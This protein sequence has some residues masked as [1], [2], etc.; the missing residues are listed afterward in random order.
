MKKIA[1]I[2]LFLSTAAEA[3]LSG[4]ITLQAQN[5]L[6]DALYSNQLD[7]DFSASIQRKYTTAWNNGDDIF[8]GQI[9]GRMGS[10]DEE[11]N[12]MDIREL[13]WLHLAGD[14]EWRIGIDTVFW[15]VTESQN[16]VDVINQKD[17]VEGI[18]NEKKLG[19]P[20]LQFS[21]I[22]DWGVIESYLLFGFRE[23]TFAGE[24]GRLR[25]PLV[26]STSNAL[27]ES[28]E[29]EDHVDYAI[30]Y[31]HFYDDIDYAVSLFRGT[32]REPVLKQVTIN[33]A[34]VL[35]P[36]YVQIT[37]IGVEAQTI[38]D[39][40]LWKFEGIIVDSKDE[41][42]TAITSGFEY[43]FYGVAESSADVGTIVEY[44]YD[45]RGDNAP[46]PLNQDLFLGARLT[47]NDIQSSSVLA[48]MVID[49]SN[50]TRVMR[51]E[52][53]RR[54]GDDWKLSGE[55]LL[56]GNIDSADLLYA[57]RNDNALKLELTYFF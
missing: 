16:L 43:T 50:Q 30:R 17:A 41:D 13:T 52:G 31:S 36:N 51:I 25:A 57:Y 6:D 21:A 29:G 32:Q 48:G 40:W 49:I 11:K 37:Q 12:H 3:E 39:A 20:M 45:S 4:S 47:F 18:D 19:Q 5:F 46:T 44:L 14:Y 42:H 22:K 33:G 34:M 24:E 28:K 27:Y 23:R 55:V 15:G 53:E 56:Y 35:Q 54:L 8:T 38:V 1:L 7:K 26:V 9:F 10:Q 2:A